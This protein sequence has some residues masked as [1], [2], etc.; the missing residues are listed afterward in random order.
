M[1]RL[2]SRLPL[3]LQIGLIALIGVVGLAVLGTTY[4]VSDLSLTRMQ[5]RLDMARAAHET[6]NGIDTGLL[7]AR[8]NEKDFLLRKQ[9]RYLTQHAAVIKE[10]LAKVQ[11]LPGYL[12]DADAA[13]K[14]RAI[15]PGIETYVSR[16]N[17]VGQA[18]IRLGLNETKGL[19]GALRTSVRDVEAILAKDDD[20][21]LDVLM[22]MMRRHEKD[23]IMR[24]DPRYGEE[25]KA[26]AAQFA[27]ALAASPLPAAVRTEIAAKMADYQRDFAALM[28]GTLGVQ[29]DIRVLSDAYA[30]L[31]P[32]L[33]SVDEKVR[34]EYAAVGAAMLAARDTTSFAMYCTIGL[35]TLA[36][37]VFGL[38]VGGGVSRPVIG[39]TDSMGRLAGGDKTVDI[40]GVG[41]GDEV[42]RMA[43]AVK[44]F[45]DSM[46]K[47]EAL[48]AE[49]AVE[50]ERKEKRRVAIESYIA[51]FDRVMT[52]ALRTVTAAAEELQRTA[53]AM[54]GTAE[55][56]QRQA[57]AVAAGAE[58]ASTNV[59][60]VAAAT[61]EL[62]AS[63]EEISRQMAQSNAVTNRAVDETEKTT[64][65]VQSLSQAAQK[66]GDVV[67]LINA[68]AGQPN[69]LALNATIEA[70]RAG[71]AGKGF[72]VVASEVKNLATQTAKAT[73]D[74][75]SQVNAIQ[76]AT[77]G[78]VEAIRVISGTIG[79]V[80]TI[81][82]TI[83]AAVEEQGR[84][85]RRSHA[86][87]SRRLPARPRSRRISAASPR[88]P[89]TRGPPPP[90]S[91]VPRA[92][93]PARARCCA[94][95]SASSWPTSAPRKRRRKPRRLSL[96]ERLS[97]LPRCL[98]AGDA[99]IAEQPVVEAG[100]RPALPGARD[101]R[102][103]RCDQRLQPEAARADI[104]I[105]RK[106]GDHRRSPDGGCHAPELALR[107][108]VRPLRTLRSR[109]NCRS[110]FFRGGRPRVAA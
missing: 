58:E 98:D 78:A 51:S 60:T 79:E 15:A 100:Q 46:I 56:T 35:V 109:S 47:A 55:E 96:P 5:G 22:L 82:T 65:S 52:E 97:D 12:S 81:A 73:E 53:Q 54:S 108:P 13:A 104:G 77:G 72:A 41:R 34:A 6:L 4:L 44:V 16:F 25:M 87:C 30:A 89:T 28:A 45:K 74:I 19:Q 107:R 94:A 24:L 23:F 63:I 2:L 1:S 9:E 42:G 31:E 67:K 103:D 11:A 57:G 95:R 68:I 59:Q 91:S 26:R 14:A 86:T 17:A 75:A 8:R 40:P 93:L 62:S 37:V 105:K 36:V 85:P 7:Q 61:E 38:V 3:R 20:Q 90:R 70:A 43:E 71:D 48:A 21:K 92:I 76:G 10:T 106:R 32:V 69:L 80:K 33:A 102:Q 66:I 49:Q 83:A 29:N 88:R 39:M 101:H 64:V 18:H 110:C 50:A 99:D 27:T 84:R